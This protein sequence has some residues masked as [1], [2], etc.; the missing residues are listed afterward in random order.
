MSVD[1]HYVFIMA[2]YLSTF[3]TLYG[4]FEYNGHLGHRLLDVY[5]LRQKRRIPAL[6]VTYS[7]LNDDKFLC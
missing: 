7:H 3:G 2:K 5:R 1:S 4:R 6:Y